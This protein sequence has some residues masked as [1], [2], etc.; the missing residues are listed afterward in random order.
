MPDPLEVGAV[1]T[2]RGAAR[3]LNK[4]WCRP[5]WRV[6]GWDDR[7]VQGRSVDQGQLTDVQGWVG[8]LLPPGG[9]FAFLAEHRR[10]LF[11]DE[12]FADLFPSGRGRPSVPADVVATVIVLQALHGLSDRDAADAVTFDLR[13]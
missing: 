2:P 10:H 13:W 6:G 1:Q 5:G 8:H 9:V 4:G 12:L 11:G 3:L 7:R